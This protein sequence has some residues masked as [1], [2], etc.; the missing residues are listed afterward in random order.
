MQHLW[1]R[2][3]RSVELATAY[4]EL[5]DPVVQRERFEAQARAHGARR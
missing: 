1:G 3:I 2:Y 5:V 4:S